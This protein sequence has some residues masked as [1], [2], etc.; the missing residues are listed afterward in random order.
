MTEFAIYGGVDHRGTVGKVAFGLFAQEAHSDRQVRVMFA[1]TPQ[2]RIR[3]GCL[4]R[5][6]DA[7][8]GE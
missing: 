1:C 4:T 6:S 2:H 3:V 8:F 7:G 5:L